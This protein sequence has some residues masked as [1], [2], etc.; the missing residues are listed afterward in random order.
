[1]AKIYDS[2]ADAHEDA[3]LAP[4]VKL[5]TVSALS[6]DGADMIRAYTSDEAAYAT[7]GR[8]PAGLVDPDDGP[9]LHPR[10]SIEANFAD[11]ELI[12]A[13]GCTACINVPI[14]EDGTLIGS[15]N[16]LDEESRYDQSS[17]T[18]AVEVSEGVRG[19]VIAYRA[20]L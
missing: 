17:L 9:V 4:G 16:F 10:A 12:F 19:L 7:G 2:F 8:K 6:S 14:I 15:V 5:F 20:A 18:R 13:L 1:M 3:R 11:K